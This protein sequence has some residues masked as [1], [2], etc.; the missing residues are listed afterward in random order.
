[1][2][3]KLKKVSDLPDALEIKEFIDNSKGSVG[4]REIARAFGIKGSKRIALKQYL[5]QLVA[6]GSITLSGRKRV[7]TKNS[8]PP[9]TVLEVLKI[10]DD[11]AAFGRPLKTN[12]INPNIKVS[13][14]LSGKGP[15]FSEGDKVLAKI[16]KISS[17]FY[18]ASVIRRLDNTKTKILGVVG[19]GNDGL[20]VNPISGR[21]SEEAIVEEDSCLAV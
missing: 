5:R 11:G 17:N 21:R 10:T 12:G 8:L 2:A 15:S 7:S 18:K 6:E 19:E 3:R 20:R 14:H 9:S 1:M 4:R 13:I 16:S